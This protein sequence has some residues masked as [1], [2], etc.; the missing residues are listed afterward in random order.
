MTPRPGGPVRPHVA[1]LP[2][3][4]LD[5]PKRHALLE[6]V[7]IARWAGIGGADSRVAIERCGQAKRPGLATV[8]AWP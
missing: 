8:L 5:R 4:R 7:L 3:P 1:V 6:I 2:G